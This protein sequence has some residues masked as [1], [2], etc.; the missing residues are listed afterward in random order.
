MSSATVLR[1]MNNLITE[2][3]Y[4]ITSYNYG[5]MQLWL[6][7]LLV[8]VSTGPI[9]TT[10]IGLWISLDFPMSHSHGSRRRYS[11]QVP[12]LLI[13]PYTEYIFQVQLKV[14]RSNYI[15]TIIHNLA[16][17]NTLLGFSLPKKTKSET[18]TTTTTAVRSKAS[19]PIG[20]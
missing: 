13:T 20:Y 16:A 8:P 15:K 11:V 9:F 17:R 19:V 3:C 1:S 12:Y 10:S 7:V 18:T 2:H 4:C 6:G 14:R 5:V